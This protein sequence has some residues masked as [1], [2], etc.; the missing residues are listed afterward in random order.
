MWTVELA[1]TVEFDATYLWRFSS[2]LPDLHHI[3]YDGQ[4][5]LNAN[6]GFLTWKIWYV[7]V[8][9]TNTLES[10]FNILY[11]KIVLENINANLTAFLA[12]YN[13]N[14]MMSLMNILLRPKKL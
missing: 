6:F 9:T 10:P 13:N 2:G 4:A 5:R 1:M 12:L 11:L 3:V 7:M 14:R 8:N